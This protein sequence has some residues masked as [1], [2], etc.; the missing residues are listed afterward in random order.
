MKR[1]LPIEY[2]RNLAAKWLLNAKSTEEIPQWLESRPAVVVNGRV[3][4]LAQEQVFQCAHCGALDPDW[5]ITETVVALQEILSA[6]HVEV[7]VVCSVVPRLMI[8]STTREDRS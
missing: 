3:Y 1:L 6:K 5:K 8:D 4:I 7:D 2:M